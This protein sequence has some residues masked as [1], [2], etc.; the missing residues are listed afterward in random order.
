MHLHALFLAS[1]PTVF[2]A[3][4]RREDGYFGY[5][6]HSRGDDPQAAVYQTENTDTSGGVPLSPI[7]D[8]YL[9]AS[10]SVGEINIQVDN[11]TARIEASDERERSQRHYLTEHAKWDRKAYAALVQAGIDID[12]PPSIF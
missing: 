4:A 8:V 5:E 9:N 2:A 12:P 6:L 7:P 11:L 3:L 1:L 10:V